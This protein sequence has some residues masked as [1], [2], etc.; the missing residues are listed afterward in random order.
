VKNDRI[1]IDTEIPMEAMDELVNAVDDIEQCQEPIY[2]F[3]PEISDDNDND[4]E[5]YLLK[6]ALYLRQFR[7]TS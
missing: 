5:N 4:I 2:G 7:E 1:E 3:I 6:A